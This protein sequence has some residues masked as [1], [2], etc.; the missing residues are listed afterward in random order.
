MDRDTETLYEAVWAFTHPVL[1]K[2]RAVSGYWKDDTLYLTVY[3]QGELSDEETEDITD[4][5]GLTISNFHGTF[6]E[7]QML[8]WDEPKPLPL[9]QNWL[10][11]PP[12]EWV[13]G[14]YAKQTKLSM[15]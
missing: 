3:Y 2:V 6:L 11:P 15:I 4:A 5:T 7:E 9:N 10:Y 14:L 13:D 8:R 12:K 1:P